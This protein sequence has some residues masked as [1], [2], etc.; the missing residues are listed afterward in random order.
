MRDHPLTP[1]TDANLV[2]VLGRQT[3]LSV[4]LVPFADVEKGSGAMRS[5]FQ[6]LAAA[7]HQVAIVDAVLDRHIDAIGSA[8]SDLPLVTGGAALGGAFAR[9]AATGRAPLDIASA[10]IRSGPAAVLSGSGSAATLAQ[11]RRLSQDVPHRAVDPLALARDGAELSDLLGWACDQARHGPVL[12]YSTTSPEAVR[13]AQHEL[14]RGQA[15]ALIEQAFGALAAALAAQGVRTF[16]VAGGETSG[17]V[18]E[19]LGIRMLGFG[20][21]IQPGVPWT[22]S[23]EPEGFHLALKSGNFGQ[24]DFFVKALEAR[25]A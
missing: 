18:L 19:A 12:V 20:D 6:S 22:W 4:G 23:L 16:V 25:T 11:V 1:M 3:A 14:G 2:R 8:C 9:A 15:A 5:C 21:E 17:A 13:H 10:P 7:R 24:A